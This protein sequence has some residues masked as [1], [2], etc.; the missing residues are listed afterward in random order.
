MTET[1][2]KV[3]RCSAISTSFYNIPNDGIF[4]NINETAIEG[5]QGLCGGIPDLKLPLCS[6]HSTKKRS[7]KLIMAISISSAI[8]LLI[9]LLALFAYW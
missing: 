5:N 3:S 9:L 7:L 6:T 4:L 8:L 1:I 2:E